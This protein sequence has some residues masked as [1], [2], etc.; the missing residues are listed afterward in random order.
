MAPAT[1]TFKHVFPNEPTDAEIDDILHKIVQTFHQLELG[2]THLIGYMMNNAKQWVQDL[3][4][5]SMW[6]IISLDWNS[7]NSAAQAIYDKVYN[8]STDTLPSCARVVYDDP[9]AWVLWSDDNIDKDNY[10]L[11]SVTFDQDDKFVIREW[12]SSAVIEPSS[13]KTPDME[14][15]TITSYEK[16]R[17]EVKKMDAETVKF[18]EDWAEELS[19]E[20]EGDYTSSSIEEH[21]YDHLCMEYYPDHARAAP[22]GYIAYSKKEF[23]EYYG[24]FDGNLYWSSNIHSSTAYYLEDGEKKYTEYP[25]VGCL[26]NDDLSILNVRIHI[27]SY[28]EKLFNTLRTIIRKYVDVLYQMSDPT[29]DHTEQPPPISLCSNLNDICYTIG[30]DYDFHFTRLKSEKKRNVFKVVSNLK[31]DI[32]HYGCSTTDMFRWF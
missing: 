15:E 28:E 7:E 10:D 24:E 12:S 23:I 21:R 14:A 20:A 29:D 2:S 30:C 3:N 32:E 27:Y 13:P 17:K 11:F 26:F 6:F 18:Y 5:W 19:K 4:E 9:H 22:N 25:P 31:H 8:N 1:F 16:W